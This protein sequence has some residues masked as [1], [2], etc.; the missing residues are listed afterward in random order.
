DVGWVMRISILA[1][2]VFYACVVLAASYVVRWRTLV[3]A[4]LPAA[5]AFGEG[6]SSVPV[7]NLVLV[8]G[9]LGI[10]SAWIAGFAAAVRVLN[11]LRRQLQMGG[12]CLGVGGGL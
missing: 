9:L 2:C 3:S 8:S 7:A 6:L 5:A 4:P 11:E 12:R 1:A 10:C